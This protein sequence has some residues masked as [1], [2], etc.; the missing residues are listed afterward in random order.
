MVYSF[1]VEAFEFSVPA[2][3]VLLTKVFTRF[4]SVVNVESVFTEA[5]PVSI[6]TALCFKT[7]YQKLQKLHFALLLPMYNFYKTTIF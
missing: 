2:E 1:D 5:Q 4:F 7:A 6:L 3:F